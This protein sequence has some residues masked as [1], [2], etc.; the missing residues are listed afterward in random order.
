MNYSWKRSSNAFIFLALILYLFIC[1]SSNEIN[2]PF[3]CLI[4]DDFFKLSI[5]SIIA[6]LYLDKSNINQHFVLFFLRICKKLIVPFVICSLILTVSESFVNRVLK[7]ELGKSGPGFCYDINLILIIFVSLIIFY[8]IRNKI[9]GFFVLFVLSVALTKAIPSL[10]ALFVNVYSSVAFVCIGY[11]MFFLLGKAKIASIK[12]TDKESDNYRISICTYSLI[13][14]PAVLF[15]VLISFFLNVSDPIEVSIY[16]I[17][18]LKY[19]FVL[20]LI[21]SITSII[22]C[23]SILLGN[24]LDFDRV[25]SIKFYIFSFIPA[26]H[27]GINAV[28]IKLSFSTKN[29]H[30]SMLFKKNVFY[31]YIPSWKYLLAQMIITFVLLFIILSS[32]K[33]IISKIPFVSNIFINKEKNAEIDDN[34]K[35]IFSRFYN[36]LS[37]I[38]LSVGIILT[39]TII[40]LFKTWPN[41]SIHELLFTINSPLE[42]TGSGMVIDALVKYALPAVLFLSLIILIMVLNRKKAKTAKRIRVAY[43]ALGILMI[44]SVFVYTDK[45]LGIITYLKNLNGNDTFIK[46]RYVDTSKVQLTFP[47]KKRN[48][49][50]IYL[51][52]LEITYADKESGGA[53]SENY[54]PNLTRLAEEGEDFGPEGNYLNGGIALDGNT[55]TMGALFGDSSGVPM[56]IN[57]SS[58]AFTT[59][60]EFCKNIYMIG[61]ILKDNGYKNVCMIG[62]EASFGGLETFFKTHGDYEVYDYDYAINNGWIPEDY[63]VWWG[64]EDEKLFG[65]AKEKLSELGESD[66]PFNFTIMTMD[67]HFEDGYVCD[68][69]EDTYDDQYANVI[70]CSDIQVY[71]FV[72]WIEQQEWFDNTTIVLC[73]DHPTMDSDFCDGISKKYERRVYTN[74][75]NSAIK[76]D[77][78]ERKYATIDLFPTT[79]AAM[80]IKIDGDK[81]AWGTNLYSDEPTLMEQYDKATLN[82][83]FQKGRKYLSRLANLEVNSTLLQKAS[84][85]LYFDI[86]NNNQNKSDFKLSIPL[87]HIS[88][89]DKCELVLIDGDN[90][91]KIELKK[92]GNGDNDYFYFNMNNDSIEKYE[93]AD[94]YITIDGTKYLLSRVYFFNN[95]LNKLINSYN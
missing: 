88:I 20:I 19:A 17:S 42:G 81:L 28:I 45:K 43:L 49:I 21:I 51:E 27:W 26:F 95:Y 34:S 18:W 37:I 13:L 5:I 65:Y 32:I 41:L 78:P 16:E 92:T 87:I 7:S 53:F 29:K 54:I 15:M 67:T 4:P 75:Y 11:L 3:I 22:L 71:N 46:E 1:I 66:E 12:T 74:I 64:F 63:Y 90:S 38:V 94:I 80:G 77:G 39:A 24:E 8:L 56:L 89:I 82:D 23:F 73:G 59:Q 47:E 84:D 35:L 79:L 93:R 72:K 40:W 60:G 91:K 48:L 14:I 58:N 52:S 44:L 76:Y 33:A 9:Q 86:L 83:R 62:S 57:M 30:I 68:Q 2:I 85:G 69:C 70:H 50:Y 55:W 61:D 6:G 36:I 10:N 31:S 25:E